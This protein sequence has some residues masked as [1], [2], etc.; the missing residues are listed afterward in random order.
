MMFIKKIYRITWNYRNFF[1]II[2]MWY[3]LSDKEKIIDF[4]LVINNYSQFV[5]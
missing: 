4:M 1:A 2:V 5:V 3:S